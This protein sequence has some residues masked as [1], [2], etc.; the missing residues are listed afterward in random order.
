MPDR[1]LDKII[2]QVVFQGT[3]TTLNGIPFEADRSVISVKKL[4][5]K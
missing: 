3:A 1:P 5:D 2:N 4:E